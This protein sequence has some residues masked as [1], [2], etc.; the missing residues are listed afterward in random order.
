[1][2]D[3]RV[4]DSFALDAIRRVALPLRFRVWR[5]TQAGNY[6]VRARL[7]APAACTFVTAV[8]Y[9]YPEN[10]ETSCCRSIRFSFFYGVDAEK[11]EGEGDRSHIILNK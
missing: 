7:F 6:F 9:F 5:E 10:T 4:R 8:P 3:E 1:M 2:P 11:T